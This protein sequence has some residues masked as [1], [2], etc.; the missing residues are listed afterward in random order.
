VRPMPRKRQRHKFAQISS[1]ALAASVL[2]VCSF[3][4]IYNRGDIIEL[5]RSPAAIPLAKPD[6]TGMLLSPVSGNTC[7]QRLI[8]NTTGQMRDNGLVDCHAAAAKAEQEWT[9]EMAVR[10]QTIFRNGF[11]N[12]TGEDGR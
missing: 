1:C 8:D 2:F 7:R 12:A 11:T 5:F 9:Q 6:V 4:A 10:R 3:A